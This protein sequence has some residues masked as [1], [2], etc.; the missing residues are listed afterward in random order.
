V[1]L[2][3]AEFE[4]SEFGELPRGW[5]VGSL[6]EVADLLSGGTPKTDRQEYW[7]G[8][9]L[10]A[11]AKDVSQCRGSFL[12]H[13]ARLITARGLAESPTQMIPFLASVVVARGATTGRMAILGEAMAMNQTC[14]ALASEDDTP[15]WLHLQLRHVIGDLVHAAHGSV[16]DTITTSTFA[17]TKVV[18]PPA[19]LRRAFEEFADPVLRRVL[20]C[21]RESR[22]LAQM[23]DGLLPRLISGE[24]RPY[25][26]DRIIE[27]RPA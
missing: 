11:S 8:D 5:R 18:L 24:I 13:T 21:A 4:N 14:Y 2:F 12:L 22:V 23:R 17:S 1:G 16:F 7:G 26:A 10:W 9:V 20:A 27:E 3:P 15:F 19:P 6:L 25:G